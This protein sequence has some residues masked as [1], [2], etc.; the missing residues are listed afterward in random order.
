MKVYRVTPGD[1]LTVAVFMTADEL[2]GFLSSH[3]GTVQVKTI[4]LH[5][6]E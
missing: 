5:D 6:E 2:Q 1:S 4:D 3:V